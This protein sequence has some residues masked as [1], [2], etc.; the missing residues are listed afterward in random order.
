MIYLPIIRLRHKRRVRIRALRGF[1]SKVILLGAK[2]ILFWEK[3]KAIKYCRKMGSP[4]ITR[5][6]N[7]FLMF[8]VIFL[9]CYSNTN[10][11]ILRL[12]FLSQKEKKIL[13]Y[14][15]FY[16]FFLFTAVHSKYKVL[17]FTAHFIYLG[18]NLLN[19]LFK[20]A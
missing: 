3:S 16:N 7:D 4:K 19:T 8:R 1:S 17:S 14:F 10:L 13:F 12:I 2:P 9:P 15:K 5:L 20:T 18:I 11:Y 6:F